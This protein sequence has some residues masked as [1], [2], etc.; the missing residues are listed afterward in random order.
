[1]TPTK[2]KIPTWQ[3]MLE[4]LEEW[5]NIYDDELEYHE[6]EHNFYSLWG[7]DL[8][9]LTSMLDFDRF[10]DKCIEYAPRS[11]RERR[12]IKAKDIVHS[13]SYVTIKGLKNVWR[14]VKNGEWQDDYHEVPLVVYI[15]EIEKY[16]V[17][18]GNHRTTVLAILD[19]EI[20]CEIVDSPLLS[21]VLSLFVKDYWGVK[22]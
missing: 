18:N 22:Y 6:S 16:L 13:Q 3:E 8:E 11:N 12:K 7:N 14:L 17:F 5:G 21:D 15:P 19:M 4:E 9:P 10:V 1:M 2:T 20:T